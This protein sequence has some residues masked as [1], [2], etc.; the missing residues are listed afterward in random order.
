MFQVIYY[1]KAHRER[2]RS[3]SEPFREKKDAEQWLKEIKELQPLM[4]GTVIEYEEKEE[5][6]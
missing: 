4:E 1:N 3:Y 6:T 5:E 2:G